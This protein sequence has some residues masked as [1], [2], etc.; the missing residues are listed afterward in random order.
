[1][2]YSG[3]TSIST[4]SFHA[5]HHIWGYV[6]FAAETIIFVL[7]GII[8]GDRIVHDQFQVSDPENSPA[9]SFIDIW[10]VIAGYILLHLIRFL[11][12]LLFWPIL[13]KIGY[14]MTFNQVLL[15]TYAGLRGAVGMSLALMVFAEP[16]IEN[17]YIKDIILLHISG[18]AFLTL[19]INATT[20]AKVVQYLNLSP[21]SDLKKNLL[22]NVSN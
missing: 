5:L 17:K 11:M 19:V 8:I 15:G 7:S 16:R 3:K 14:G 10:K 9:I 2:S 22:L 13:R 6:G 4:E 12:I 21:Y 20:T 1:M 18:V